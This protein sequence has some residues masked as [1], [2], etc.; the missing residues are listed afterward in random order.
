MVGLVEKILNSH[1]VFKFLWF[2]IDEGHCIIGEFGSRLQ[3]WMW[4]VKFD[5]LNGG[6]LEKTWIHILCFIFDKGHCITGEFVLRF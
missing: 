3:V 5:F 2:I 6:A 1:L 4:Y